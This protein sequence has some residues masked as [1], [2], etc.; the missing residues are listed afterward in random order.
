MKGKISELFR[1]SIVLVVLVGW[2]VKEGIAQPT[3]TAADYNKALWMTTRFY[4]GQRSGENNWLIYNHLPAGV[5][6]ALTGKSFIA[7]ADGANDLSG[8]WHDCGDHVKFGQTQFYAAYMLLKGYAEFPTGYDDKYTLEYTGY[9]AAGNWTWEGSGHDPNCIPD[10]LEEVKHATDFFIKVTPSASRFYYEVGD[11]NA[12]H[13]Q[14]VTSV[15]M[16]TLAQGQG[17][18]PRVSCK[19]P[20]DAAMASLCGATLAL[21]SR[22][23]APYD[24]AYAANC[25]THAQYAY[26][27]ASTHPGAVGACTGSFYG[28]NN[29]WKNAWAI[30]L[31]EMY[32]ATLN[33]SY[34]TTALALSVSGT[35]TADVQPNL[36]WAFDYVNN[37]EL[38][39][40]VLGQLGNASATTA[41]NTRM[42]NYWLA[43]GNR[44]GNG[45]YTKDG[46]WGRLRYNGNAAFLV[47]LYCKLNSITS[48]A[49]Y[50]LIYKDVD[51]I[52]GGNGSKRSYI[53]GFSPAAGGPYVTPQYPHHRNVY[54]RDDNPGNG[55]VLTIPTKNQQLGALVGGQR[56]GTYND[57]RSDYEN[58]EV[59][60]DYNAGLVGALGYIKS[61]LAPVSLSCGANACRKPDIG[62]DLSICST[63]FPIT[64]T[65]ANTTT[66]PSGVTYTWKRVT[67]TPIVNPVG[68][69]G[70]SARI[71]IIAASDCPS[72]PC[73]IVVVRDS[74]YTTPTAGT[75]SKTDTVTITNTIPTPVLT[76]PLALCT[77]ASYDITPT[78]VSSF[79]AGVTWQWAVDYSGGT[80]YN[81]LTGETAST[82]SNVRT[83]GRYRITATAGSCTNNANVVVT[84]S[85]PTPVDGCI[86]S[87]GNVTLSITNPGLTGTN[88]NWY[89]TASGST[90][91]TTVPAGNATAT[92]SVTVNVGTTTTFYVQDMNS[93]NATVGPYFPAQPTTYSGGSNVGA[94]S[95]IETRFEAIGNF[96][97]TNLY[98][99]YV[100]YN[101]SEA[102]KLATFEIFDETSN[103]VIATTSQYTGALA[104][105]SYGSQGVYVVKFNVNIPI[106]GG[107]SASPAILRIRLSGSSNSGNPYLFNDNVDP[108][109]G[110]MPLA[111]KY[112]DNQ[113]GNTM[114]L[115]GSRIYS[116]ATT[117]RYGFFVGFNISAGTGCARVPVIARVSS[118]CTSAPVELV[119]FYA[120]KGEGRTVLNWV[121]ASEL[122]ND[123]FNVERSL[124]GETFEVIS[125][126]KGQGT[127]SGISLYSFADEQT[128]SGKAYYRLTQVD[129][130]GTATRSHVI[131]VEQ[132]I[133][134]LEVQAA[135][136]PFTNSTDVHITSSLSD[137]ARVVLTDL[138]GLHVYAGI[139]PT[140][141]A[142]SVGQNIA[143]GVYILQVYLQDQIKTIRIIKQ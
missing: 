46:S 88:Y 63:T 84:S 92:T 120:D 116:T 43:A 34:R 105:G 119:S 86:S 29:N 33:T 103:A 139:H 125:K 81:N 5:P 49:T 4:G 138:S 14:W 53:V 52:M 95:Q 1:F 15:K 111:W 126:V 51:Y 64:L 67:P 70:G 133:V 25:L 93:V 21:M 82:L 141:E 114:R 62:A 130:D 140:N 57:D 100:L 41:F 129:Y 22:M 123:Y 27:Y 121:T 59:C 109:D 60:I 18:N 102:A 37:G 94:D 42:V 45:V 19:D 16:Q 56:N 24:A 12:D 38:A 44:D 91:A 90:L 135:P 3:F 134:S 6:A 40:Y 8:G 13:Q 89:T 20:N 136:N 55:V 118:G 73:Q 97:I 79:P 10:I 31:S 23:Y 74:T 132:G 110:S 98:I 78:N 108:F 115:I 75:C 17:G 66:I 87:A 65:D 26:A 11:G 28:A 2:F 9:K 71:R 68:T 142:V 76:G 50:N 61:R 58:T 47:S 137:K 39:L 124:D 122:N 128:P 30:L 48:G 96:S 117:S 127:I 35:G 80:T 112:V 36:G 83:A 101:A 131:S 143:A 85:N 72:F 7:D 113:G 106:T 77:P 107:T 69:A 99:P 32:W 54:L 104:S